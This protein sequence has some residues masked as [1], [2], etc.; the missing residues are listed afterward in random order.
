VTG[1]AMEAAQSAKQEKVRSAQGKFQH[2]LLSKTPTRKIRIK[3]SL[4][5]SIFDILNNSSTSLK[6]I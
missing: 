3:M 2:P 1:D 5:C 4:L 6:K